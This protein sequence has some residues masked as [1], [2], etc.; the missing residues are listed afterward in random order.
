MLIDFS[1]S[2]D[3]GSVAK[4][5]QHPHVGHS[6][7]IGQM[8]KLAPSPLLREHR[9]QQ[10][11]G[12]HWRQHTQQMHPPQ[13]GRAQPALSALPAMRRQ[14]LIDKIVGNVRGKFVEQLDRASG[15]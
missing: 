10:I 8:G 1:Q 6:V 15:R 2:T 14:Q 11:E 9:H 4:L 5:V 12:M 3:S 7:A 13:L